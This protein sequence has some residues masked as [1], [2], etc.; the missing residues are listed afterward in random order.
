MLG[1]AAAARAE[2]PTEVSTRVQALARQGAGALLAD[3]T[4]RVEVTVGE[5]N[6]RLRLA[7]CSQIQ[8]YLLPGLPVW[9][10][11]RVGLRC[12]DGTARWN[13]SLPLT[14]KVFAKVL[15]AHG[16][17]PAGA[18]L[19]AGQ[20]DVAEADIAAEPGGVFTDAKDLI[21]RKLDRPVEAGEAL[22]TTDMEKRHWF[23]AG[24]RVKVHAMGAGFSVDG[25][26]QALSIGLDKEDARIRLDN[27]RTVTGRA[28]GEHVV[29][30]W[31]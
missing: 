21:G 10:R 25:E 23:A 6:P 8:P 2:V 11:T 9:G 16:A 28:V 1:A 14:V 17:L 27:G 7:P 13:V 4:A 26:G 18:V 20:F 12:I 31:L 19:E 3:R 15:V 5:L 30:V 24:D 29:E 22:R